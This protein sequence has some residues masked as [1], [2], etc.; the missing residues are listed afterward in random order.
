MVLLSLVVITWAVASWLGKVSLLRMVAHHMEKE[1]SSAL[2]Q[3]IAFRLS[4]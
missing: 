3:K 4:Q 1:G 2:L